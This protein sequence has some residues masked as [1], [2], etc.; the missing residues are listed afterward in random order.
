MKYRKDFVTNS[1]SS[2]FVCE[3]CGNVDSGYDCIASELGFAECVNGH[4]FCAS[5]KLA[6]DPGLSREE[7]I[8][9]I[10]AT[11]DFTDDDLD[12]L[13][14]DELAEIYLYHVEDREADEEYEVSSLVCPICQFA[15]YT[16]DDLAAYLEIKYGISRDEV[17]S[18]VKASLPLRK[19]ITDLEYITYVCVE[20][21][22]V[23]AKIVAAW[24]REF[25]S[26]D[27]FKKYIQKKF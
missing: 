2:S 27:A 12:Y 21:G 8:S 1:S 26:Y 20:H 15:E 17:L 10:V 5:H 22:L 18:L 9:A 19:K 24:K 11:G 14:E 25:A 6:Y 23:P 4:C 7:M 13:G 16:E 3:I